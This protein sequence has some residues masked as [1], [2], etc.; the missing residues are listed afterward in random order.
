MSPK[1]MADGGPA[2]DSPAIDPDK[3]AAMQKGATSGGTSASDAW[4][5]IKSGLGFADGGDVA[6]RSFAEM[7]KAVKAANPNSGDLPAGSAT[8]MYDQGWRPAPDN[9]A[10]GGAVGGGDDSGGIMQTAMK[11][12]PR[13]MGHGTAFE[14]EG[15]EQLRAVL[16]KALAAG[17]AV[18]AVMPKRET[19]EDVFVR[20]AL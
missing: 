4:K 19:L 15:D 5:N 18:D 14:V 10:D 16:E 2:G 3:A 12:A 7:S 6:P 8:Q 1:K 13:P 11:L 20:R 17:A 9:K